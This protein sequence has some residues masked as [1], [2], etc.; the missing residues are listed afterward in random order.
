MISIHLQKKLLSAEG[1]MELNL[2]LEI[3]K[4]AFIAICGP[5][6]S[7]KT[8]LLRLIAGLTKPDKGKILYE[9]TMWLDSTQKVNLPPQKRQLGFVFQDYALFPNMTVQGNLEYALKKNQSK[10]IIKELIAVMELA[11][12]ANRFPFKLSGGQ[13]QRVALARALVQKPGLLLLDEPLSA[14]DPEMRT[15]LQNYILKVHKTY[16]LTTI[17]VSHDQYEVAKMADRVLNMRLGKIIS[18]DLKKGRSAIQQQQQINL[19]GKILS[20]NQINQIAIIKVQI[21]ENIIEV[22]VP[23][24][25]VE[26]KQPG[27]SINLSLFTLNP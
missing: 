3:K 20:I 12:L 8:T 22:K 13:Q 6:G 5:S 11:T 14:L 10:E 24:Q 26:Q 2:D 21:G 18:D 7:G 4:G 25:E 15:K 19:I 27:E 16:K 23:I 9:N 17:L 1:K